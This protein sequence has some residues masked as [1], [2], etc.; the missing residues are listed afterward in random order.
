[1]PVKDSVLYVLCSVTVGAWPDTKQERVSVLVRPERQRSGATGQLGARS[2][3]LV[4]VFKWITSP[5]P[6]AGNTQ[7]TLRTKL[8]FG[9]SHLPGNWLKWGESVRLGEGQTP[10]RTDLEKEKEP[11]WILSRLAVPSNLLNPAIFPC[12]NSKNYAVSLTS[13]NLKTQRT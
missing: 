13:L 6:P 4:L 12:E 7:S 8:L 9:N 3:F 5:P 10:K 11:Q 1:M 2:K